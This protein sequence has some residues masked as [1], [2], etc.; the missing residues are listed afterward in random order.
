MVKI[1][2]R[3]R[4][5]DLGCVLKYLNMYMYQAVLKTKVLIFKNRNWPKL[6]ENSQNSLSGRC[7]SVSSIYWFFFFFFNLLTLRITNY[8]GHMN[9]RKTESLSFQYKRATIEVSSSFNESCVKTIHYSQLIFFFFFF[10]IAFSELHIISTD[11]DLW[12]GYF[13]A[14]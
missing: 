1:S 9:N 13:L 6:W 3:G 7:Q 8:L 11:I 10:L 2:T 12:S 5:C 4:T 14:E